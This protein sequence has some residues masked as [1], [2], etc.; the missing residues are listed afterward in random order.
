MNINSQFETIY[1]SG[2]M[3]GYLGLL[4]KL[5]R[6]QKTNIDFHHQNFEFKNWLKIKNRLKIEAVFF[7]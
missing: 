3:E 1:I 7:G 2:F 4:V 5:I 6:F